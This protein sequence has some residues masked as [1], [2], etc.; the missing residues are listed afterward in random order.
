V[1]YEVEQK[2]R[3]RDLVAVREAL[4]ARYAAFHAHIEQVDRYFAHPSR[5]F[6]LT[7][8]AFRLRRDGSAN[9]ITY[10]G[11]KIDVAVKTRREIELPLPDGADYLDQFSELLESLG[12]RHVAKVSKRRTS[13]QLTG[14]GRVV[15]VCLDEVDGLG[16]F[17]ELELVVEEP[18]LSA[19]K[20]VISSLAG[21]LGLETVIRRSYLEMLL[22]SVPA[23][24][25]TS[26]TE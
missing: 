12:F 10:K 1:K 13:V 26:D 4:L 18:D 15:H 19:A 7:D 9:R 5:D 22:D 2:Y 24:G 8:E 16:C 21:E 3:V 23:G 14:L 20:Q 25:K 17:V 11:P 6:K